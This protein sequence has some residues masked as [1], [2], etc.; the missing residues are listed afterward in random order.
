MIDF[1][2]RE[3]HFA[4]HLIPV[5]KALPVK[6]RGAFHAHG[7]SAPQLA[8]AGV[9]CTTEAIADSDRLTVAASYR[10]MKAARNAQRPVVLAEHGA[11]QSYSNTGFG[12]YIG[13]DD[14]EGVVG[15]LLP[16]EHAAE[17]HRAS[18]EIP[19][20]PIGCPKLDAVHKAPKPPSGDPVVAIS[21]HWDC[22]LCP[23]T[24]SAFPYYRSI[25]RRIGQQYNVIGHAHPRIRN[26]V[27]TRFKR[28]GIEF[29]DDFAEVIERATV[30]ACDNSSTMFEWASLDRPVVVLNSPR[31]RRRV[32][33]GMRFWE[34]AD[35]GPQVDRPGGL[36]AGIALAL[37]DPS[38]IA[39]RRREITQ[40]V[41]IATDG[42]A[43]KRAKAALIEIHGG[44][45]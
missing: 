44:I 27:R 12:S 40:Q 42:S 29:V 34:F 5:Y 17:R 9:P 20:Y 35:L 33:H 31:Y 7:S 2:A 38:E 41:Y 23:E 15:V 13:A 39:A 10:D 1:I 30:Y 28:Y 11:G 37:A 14:R 24:R 3:P 19:A 26:V 43:A 18:S 21:F 36:S 6:L 8:A 45:T 32:D 4:D 16:G 22:R 25:L